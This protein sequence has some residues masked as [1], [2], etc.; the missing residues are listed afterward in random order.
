[1]AKT[2]CSQCKRAWVQSPV[3]ELD[4]TCQDPVQQNNKNLKR[5][6]WL[7]LQHLKAWLGAQGFLPC[8]GAPS[9]SGQAG[10]DC[11][12][13][14]SVPLPG[15]LSTHQRECP[16]SLVSGSL[17]DRARQSGFRVMSCQLHLILLVMQ[18]RAEALQEGAGE[19]LNSRMVAHGRPGCHRALTALRVCMGT[20]FSLW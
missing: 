4:P 12:R 14:D 9:R 13:E 11:G 1:M 19:G 20:G 3:R 10:A 5:R 7:R 15:G 2:P 6:W 18:A 16:Y 8:S 17:Q